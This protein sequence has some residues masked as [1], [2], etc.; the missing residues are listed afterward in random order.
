VE[1]YRLTPRIDTPDLPTEA[2]NRTWFTSHFTDA[3][4]THP[5]DGDLQQHLHR[6][7]RLRP[8]HRAHRDGREA[9]VNYRQLAQETE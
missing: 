3:A 9:L 7:T 1:L 5:R 6:A 4:G 8:E 2:Q